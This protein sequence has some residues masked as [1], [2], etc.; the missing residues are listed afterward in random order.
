[1]RKDEFLQMLRRDLNGDVPSAVVEENV[2]YYDSYITEEVRKGRSKEE[3][4]AEIGD[5]RLIAKNI[6]D[7]TEETQ[8]GQYGETGSYEDTS[9]RR[10]Y[11]REERSASGGTGNIHYFDLNKWYWK[12]LLIVGLLCIFSLVFTII[13]GIFRIFSPLLYP[14]FIVWLVMTLLRTFNRR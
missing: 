2:R 11:E 14:L 12:V 8:D 13:G 1:M 6:E 7:T 5:P 4:I 10:T 3:V 9:S